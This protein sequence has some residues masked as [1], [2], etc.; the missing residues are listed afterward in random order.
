MLEAAGLVH[1]ACGSGPVAARDLCTDREGPRSAAGL[2]GAHAL[3][4]EVQ[5]KGCSAPAHLVRRLAED[6]DGLI[7]ELRAAH[8]KL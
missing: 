4:H 7:A 2:D 6:R 8:G 1:P 5:L 3:E